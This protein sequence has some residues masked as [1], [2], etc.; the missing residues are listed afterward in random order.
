MSD[1]PKAELLDLRCIWQE[2]PHNAFT[3]LIR[4]EGR[5]LCAFREGRGHVSTDGR[6]RVLASSDGLEWESIACVRLAGADLRDANLSI[7]PDGRL[8]LVSGAALREEDDARAQVGTV[9]SFSKDAVEWSEPVWLTEAGRWMWRVAWQDGRAYGVSYSAGDQRRFL[10]LHKSG[11]GTRFEV[12]LTP[13]FEQGFPT[14][15]CLEFEADGG[16]LCLVRRDK[17]QDSAFFGTAAAPYDEWRFR[18]LGL[19]VGGP[20]L[21]RLPDGRLLLAGRRKG[22]ERAEHR[23]VLWQ[24]ERESARLR[25]LLVLPSGSDTSYPGLVWFEDR[26]WMSYYSS[27][28]GE[29]AR[30]YLARIS[31]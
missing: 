5:F 25:E 10:E 17:E 14:E 4:F 19:H 15:A 2:A 8:M 12:C 24:L 22:E 30:I 20:C 27:H 28:E 31:L 18:D 29:Q 13:L 1:T 26:L 6:I 3:D 23:T 16:A 9:A 11:E 21:R 7:T